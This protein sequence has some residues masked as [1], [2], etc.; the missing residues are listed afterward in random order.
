MVNPEIGRV[1]M[2]LSPLDKIQRYCAYQDRCTQEVRIKLKSYK[3]DDAEIETILKLL[4]ND[5]FVN[6][7]R[8]VESFIRGKLRA[9]QW[10]KIKIRMHLLQKSIP[11]SLIDKYLNEVEDSSYE[12]NLKDVID[13][14]IRQHGEVSAE[15]YPKICRFLLSK[16]YAYEQIMK[17]VK[18]NN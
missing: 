7:E 6:D 15:N 10:G 14:W 1:G 2:S 3:I 8:Y 5:G 18:T 4:Q 13:K 11:A 9:K 17:S 16:G 12:E